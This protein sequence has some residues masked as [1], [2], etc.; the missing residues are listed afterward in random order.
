[1][2]V[3][4]SLHGCISRHVH[5]DCVGLKGTV[6]PR[7]TICNVPLRV[8]LFIHL[9]CFGISST[10]TSASNIE[11][12]HDTRLELHKASKNNTEKQN[13]NVFFQ[14]I[15]RKCGLYLYVRLITWWFCPYNFRLF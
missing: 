10:E 11:E 14:I 8:V 3:R 2:R 15:L 13:I 12:Q 7:I 5:V 6:H 4:V 9:E 1:M